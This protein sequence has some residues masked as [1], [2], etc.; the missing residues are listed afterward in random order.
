M[1][2]EKHQQLQNFS[3]SYQPSEIAKPA[4][5]VHASTTLIFADLKKTLIL[6][7]LFILVEVVLAVFY[8]F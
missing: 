1:L 7:S 6:G 5:P 8:K 3:F 2:A 4:S